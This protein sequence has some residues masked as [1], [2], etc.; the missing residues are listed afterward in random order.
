MKQARDPKVALVSGASRG[1]GAAIAARLAHRGHQVAGLSRAGQAPDGV[2]ALACDVSDSS[3]VDAAFKTVEDRLGSPAILV[4]NAGVINDEL[5][6]R[7]TDDAWREVIDVN[8]TGAFNVTRRALRGMLTARHGRIVLVSSVAALHGSAGQANYAAAKAGLVGMARSLAREVASRGITVNTVHP[9]FIDAGMTECV[10][11]E[12]LAQR[13]A[14]IPAGRLG[15]IEEVVS[16][17]EFLVSPQAG[18]IT[19]AM[20]PIDGGLGMGQ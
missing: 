1:I 14:E 6:A 3:A 15:E 17:V 12:L 9:G 5:A 4:V 18:Y 8:L 13:V 10:P 2:L 20:I 7:M 16:T 11:A 19:G